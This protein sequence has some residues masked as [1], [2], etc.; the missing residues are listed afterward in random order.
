M[1]LWKSQYDE[2]LTC[3]SRFKCLLYMW[4]T[5]VMSENHIDI[6]AAYVDLHVILCVLRVETDTFVLRFDSRNARDTPLTE[7]PFRDR[8]R[9]SV[10]LQTYSLTC[11]YCCSSTYRSERNER[12]RGCR[13]NLF[14]KRS[15]GS[16]RP[17]GREKATLQ[18]ERTS[19]ESL[20]NKSDI[21]TLRSFVAACKKPMR[22]KR[23]KKKKSSKSKC[24][25]R[26]RTFILT[27]P[28][29]TWP[30]QRR[31]GS[32]WTPGR[33]RYGKHANTAALLTQVFERC[34]WSAHGRARTR[35]RISTSRLHSLSLSR[36]RSEHLHS[37]GLHVTQWPAPSR[38]AFTRTPTLVSPRR[39]H[40]R[41][42]LLHN[43]PFSAGPSRP[44]SRNGT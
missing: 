23:E 41:G 20:R 4:Y 33:K 10:E 35:G 17:R 7:I 43:G 16:V 34:I 22:G 37:R 26:K 6:W 2:R 38:E 9:S 5:Y 25:R 32:A 39:S 14:L 40:H 8:K 15:S 18:N 13:E 24:P 30:G 44:G 12:N 27:V 31:T 21:E 1:Q 11:V 19:A 42:R 28:T 3:F 36:A 29:S